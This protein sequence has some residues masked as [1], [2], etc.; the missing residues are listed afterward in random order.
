MGTDIHAFVEVEVAPGAW[1]ARAQLYLDRS[2]SMFFA[3][4]GVRFERDGQHRPTW[5]RGLPKDAS[6]RVRAEH[7][8]CG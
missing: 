5:D 2:Y 3:L 8:G 6:A 1:M 4:G 7:A